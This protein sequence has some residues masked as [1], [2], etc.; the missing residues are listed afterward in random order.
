MFVFVVAGGPV[1]LVC[2]VCVWVVVWLLFLLWLFRLCVC[3]V[4]T[5]DFL[6]LCCGCVVM[7]LCFYVWLCYLFGVLVLLVVII[8]GGG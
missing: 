7:F 3:A 5:S 8:I 4:S 6:V 1:S 2:F